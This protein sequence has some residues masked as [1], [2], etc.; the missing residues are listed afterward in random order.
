MNFNIKMIS[1]VKNFKNVWTWTSLEDSK[2]EFY[3]EIEK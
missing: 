3:I 2:I 1:I